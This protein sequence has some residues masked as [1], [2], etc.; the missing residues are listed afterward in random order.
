MSEPVENQ[1]P[2]KIN[3][4]KKEKKSK[5]VN[6]PKLE[7]Q[8]AVLAFFE[9]HSTKKYN[10]RQVI[11]LIGVKDSRSSMERSLRMLVA[12]GKLA[13]NGQLTYW[14]ASKGNTIHPSQS[15]IQ[16][17]PQAEPKPKAPKANTLE[18]KVDMLRSGSAYVVCEGREDDIYI[19]NKFLGS[20]LHGD[21]V[22]VALRTR[23]GGKRAEGEIMSITERAASH[24]IGILQIRNKRAFVLPDRQNMPVDIFV[25]P[26]QLLGGKDGEKVVV[27]IV[28]WHNEFMKSPIGKVTSVLGAAGSSDIEMKSIL[29]NHGFDLDFSEETMKETAELA[30]ELSLPEIKRRRD[31]R[32]ITTFTID[33]EDAKDFDDALSY[34]ELE[35]G[36]VEIGVHIADVTH[37]VKPDTALDKEAYLR[38][39]SVYLVDRVLPMLPEKIS[40]ELCSL[41]PHEDKCTFSAVF[42]FDAEDNITKRWF[43]KTLIHSDH[44][45]SYESAQEVLDNKKG[46]LFKELT[47]MNRIALKLRKE[48]F[49]NGA[50][51]F[52]TDEVRFRLD[53]Q[54]VPLSVYIKERK[55][56]NLLIEDF[57][58]L[59]NREVG[60][61]IQQKQEQQ[62]EIPYIYRIHDTPN[63]EK[64]VELSRFAAELGFSFRI[65]SPK[66][67]AKSI[68]DLA[69]VAATNPTLKLLEPLAIRTM[70][71]AVYSSDNIGHYGLGFDNYSHF[72]SPIRRYSD[73]LAHRLLFKNLG[74]KTYREDKEILERQCKHI[75]TQERHAMEAERES[76]KYKQVEFLKKH[77]GEEFD[78]VV[79]G[80]ME[81]GIFIE[82]KDTK[83]EGMVPF[84]SMSDRFELEPS[85]LKAK[86]EFSGDIIKMGDAVRVRILSA[87]LTKRQ[88]EMELV[89]TT[90]VKK[91]PPKTMKEMMM[92]EG[93]DYF[94]KRKKKKVQP[95]KEKPVIIDAP[96]VIAPVVVIQPAEIVPVE[97]IKVKK[98]RA[99][100]VKVAAP[101]VETVPVEVIKVKKP[102]A[103]VIKAVAPIVE[104]VP[105]EVIKVKKPRAKVI[106]AAAPIV[107]I[108]PVEVIKVKKPRAKKTDK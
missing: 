30:T 4:P 54:G 99:K 69:K 47:A 8:I 5:K 93:E 11:E 49:K 20:A 48:R 53:E 92:E 63:M 19:P 51:N 77:I 34:E 75:S 102:R 3:Q 52:E 55:A 35:D 58:L 107:E 33:P 81:R 37:Y 46:I 21:R 67:I 12:E 9:K 17:Q 79:S 103:K 15:Q 71:K 31:F 59:A 68:N 100:V 29:I 72:T 76:T 62:A 22:K 78:G 50:I 18:G 66:Q 44:R 27:K 56:T 106:K 60:T 38:S 88:I 25:N 42:T 95:V 13:A 101:I 14:L 96:K 105:V 23:S 97:V 28:R 82:L 24:F 84:Q 39:T 94:V 2:Q 90:F 86:G 65:D 89:R 57:M 40:N 26:D 43:G 64:L 91:A 45:F 10:A 70:S 36:T 83:C 1:T 16:P 32:K 6:T 80:M 104:I 41:R 61:F 98:P 7:L 74:D 108:V 73:V 85:R 87:D